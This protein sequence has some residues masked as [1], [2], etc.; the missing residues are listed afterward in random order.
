MAL[1]VRTGK[2]DHHGRFRELSSGYLDAT[3]VRKLALEA[4]TS[5]GSSL[6]PTIL[7]LPTRLDPADITLI[8]AAATATVLTV[9]CNVVPETHGCDRDGSPDIKGCG[10]Y[11]DLQHAAGV[12]TRYCHM[13]TQPFVHEGQSVVV[14][15][16]LG[17]VGSSGNSS[18]PHLHY[19]THL[20]GDRT[21]TGAVDPVR[22]MREV[23]APLGETS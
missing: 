1:S 2:I 19:E 14:G 5:G 9:R 6:V 13:Q 11:V 20:H 18:G 16:P 12:I 15:Q 21:A 4:I 8:R 7:F 3:A 22:F 10:W 23:G 17:L